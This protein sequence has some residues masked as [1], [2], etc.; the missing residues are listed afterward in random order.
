MGCA[1]SPCLARLALP[2]PFLSFERARAMDAGA[3]SPA[4][5][6][7]EVADRSR[8]PPG[9]RE[10]EPT[11]PAMGAPFP[12]SPLTGNAL[13]AM[14]L[15]ATLR[16]CAAASAELAECRNL[17]YQALVENHQVRR[18]VAWQEARIKLLENIILK[19]PHLLGALEPDAD[20]LAVYE[21]LPN[22]QAFHREGDRTIC[23]LSC[24]EN[25]DDVKGKVKGKAGTEIAGRA[26]QQAEQ[27]VGSGKPGNVN[28]QTLS[29]IFARSL[30]MDGGL[31]VFAQHGKGSI[32]GTGNS[33]SSTAGGKGKSKD[34]K[35]ETM[36]ADGEA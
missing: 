23:E 28:H 8:S 10:R 2:E 19:G 21:G 15:D 6:A 5:S 24:Q 7:V 3:A 32:I 36:T 35:D 22:L 1:R 20:S 30:M 9:E 16:G 27:R 14:H 34:S 4:S 12:P 11:T 33:S 13:V 17:L 31:S 26:W 18:H 29:Q 25:F